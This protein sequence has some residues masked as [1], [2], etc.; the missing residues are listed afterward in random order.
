MTFN[1]FQ[2]YLY[3]IFHSAH[4]SFHHTFLFIGILCIIFTFIVL[5]Y[6]RKKKIKIIIDIPPIMGDFAYIPLT[7]GITCII[8]DF[9]MHLFT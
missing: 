5:L 1:I 7:V 2:N 6:R 9:L 8:F 3:F 4:N